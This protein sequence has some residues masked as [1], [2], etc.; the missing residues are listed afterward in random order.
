MTLWKGK[1][2]KSAWAEKAAVLLLATTE[3]AKAAMPEE[4]T[5][6]AAEAVHRTS[7][8]E[9]LLWLTGFLSRQAVAEW[10]VETPMQMQVMPAAMTEVKGIVPLEKA[11]TEPHKILAALA[12]HLGLDRE[13]TVMEADSALEATAP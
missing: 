6:A 11:V 5:V 2:W 4:R 1:F 10:A 12:V 13:M 8:S 3:G 7:E 9:V